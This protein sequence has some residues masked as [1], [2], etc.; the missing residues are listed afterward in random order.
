MTPNNCL[1][2]F[3]RQRGWALRCLAAKSGIP[4]STLSD[5]ERYDYR[6]SSRTKQRLADVLG[7][8]VVDIWPAL[9]ETGSSGGKAVRVDKT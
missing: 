9:Q 3:R 2:E 1:R 6:P 8:D 7:L 5:I 4:A